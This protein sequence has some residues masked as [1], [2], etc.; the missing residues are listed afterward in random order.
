MVNP[1]VH[2][3]IDVRAL[4]QRIS[5]FAN[6]FG[7]AYISLSLRDIGSESSGSIQMQAKG[8]SLEESPK[9]SL[10]RNRF[11]FIWRNAFGI[12]TRRSSSGGPHRCM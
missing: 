6:Q 1:S 10:A 4:M 3:R 9:N 8:D 2:L 5:I 12:A 11:V 7:P